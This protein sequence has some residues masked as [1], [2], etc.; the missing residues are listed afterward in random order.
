MNWRPRYRSKWSRARG[1]L[2]IAAFGLGGLALSYE[3]PSSESGYL[4][5]WVAAWLALGLTLL[6]VRR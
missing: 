3:M 1:P 4:L 6:A 5:G 2:I